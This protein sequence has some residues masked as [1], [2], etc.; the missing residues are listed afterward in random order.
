MFGAKPLTMLNTPAR[1]DRGENDKYEAAL[2]YMDKML[3]DIPA[4]DEFQTHIVINASQTLSH[5]E[6][7]DAIK[8]QEPIRNLLI[9]EFQYAKPTDAYP[10]KLTDIGRLAKK[11]GGHFKYLE[12]L[13]RPVNPIGTFEG[14]CI[15]VL[16]EYDK[17]ERDRGMPIAEMMARAEVPE[18]YQIAVKQELSQKKHLRCYIG[19]PDCT[20]TNEGRTYLAKYELGDNPT[21]L[22]HQSISDSI[23]LSHSNF[24]GNLNT[25]NENNQSLNLDAHLP[26]EVPSAK[27][28]KSKILK[29]IQSIVTWTISNLW[30]IAIPL[31]VAYLTYRLGFKK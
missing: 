5:E 28:T 29:A 15:A 17:I 20:M 13:N 16:K 4:F 3:S 1:D 21:P 10:L 31:I 12:S 2:K 27:T 6:K 26:A 14:Y 19:I 22:F 25:G 9:E 30:K 7:I 18:K 11:V 24:T 23:V 8:L